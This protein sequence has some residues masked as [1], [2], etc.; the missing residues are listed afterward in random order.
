MP[1]VV[2]LLGGWFHRW[3]ADDAYIDFRVIHNIWSGYGPVFNPGERVEV[4]TDPLWVFLLTVVGR[5]FPF[6]NLAWWAVVLGLV[7]TASGFV[8]AARASQRLVAWVGWRPA[9]PVGLAVAA[10]LD[11]FWDF[12]TSGLETGLIFAWEGAC[13]W[14]LVRCL[15]VRRGVTITAIVVGLG[16]LIR[17]DLGLFTITYALVLVYVVARTSIGK[18]RGWV[19]RWALP[20][21]GLVAVP[22]GYEVWRM[23]Y[24]ALLLPNTA[25]AKSSGSS[26]WSQ[27]YTYFR[28]FYGSN[29]LYLVVAVL[30]CIVGTNVIVALRSGNHLLAVVVTAPLGGAILNCAY[31][32]RVGGDFMHARMLLPSFFALATVAWISLPRPRTARFLVL[33]TLSAWVLLSS[34][35]MRYN[36]PVESATTGISNERLFWVYYSRSRHPITLEDYRRN[37]DVIE[38]KF[39]AHLA[40]QIPQGQYAVV[41]GYVDV[42]RRTYWIVI[43][44]AFP[45]RGP[46]R[47]T[48]P[49]V[50][51]GLM[52]VAAGDH[53]YLYDRYSLANPI[54][55]HMTLEK[56]G[57]PGHEKDAAVVWM[58]ARFVPEKTNLPPDLGTPAVVAAARQAIH[59]EPLKAY[60]N[61]ITAPLTAH[62]I[63]SNML[64]SLTYTRMTFSDQ[65]TLAVGQL[66][67]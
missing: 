14:L 4:Y 30:L 53:V 67:S 31:V 44:D 33:G 37:P 8:L 59:C 48:A 19:Y 35:A 57:R 39:L 17:P 28:D 7:S 1:A 34:V 51:M 6:V 58:T 45:L 24:F 27:G 65:P 42:D 54:G 38:G 41:G 11:A 15:T 36:G 60:L 3:V 22:L 49:F 64:H 13:W 18:D 20:A 46:E 47:V 16:P 10:S 40:A 25:I 63:L 56:R 21:A 29:H 9:I 43:S 62:Q 2:V 55:S 23:A 61:G 50:H 26:W 12:S 32:V 52:G 5:V 66:C